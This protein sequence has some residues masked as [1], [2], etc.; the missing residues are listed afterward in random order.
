MGK[1]IVSWSPIH[2]QSATTTNIAALASMFALKVPSTN[3]ITH[4]QLSFSTLES[5]FGKEVIVEGFED[6][7]INAL[8]R[9]IKSNL[10]KPEAVMDYTETIYSKRLEILGGMKKAESNMDTLMDILIL[11]IR[12]AY[13]FLWIDAHSGQQNPLSNRLLADADVVLVNLPQ[14]RYILDR[15]FKGDLFPDVL[16]NKPHVVLIANYDENLSLSIRKIK[17]R[18]GVKTPIFPVNYSSQLKNACNELGLAEFFYRNQLVEKGNPSYPYIKSLEK[19]NKFIS[20]E[21][22]FSRS[23]LDV[24][25]GD[26]DE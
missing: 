19:I 18:Y 1:T 13:D 23:F 9:L 22:G 15:F 12:E 24:D 11:A 2:G 10:L 8:E 17:R 16:K 14:N 20:K 6:A 5:L 26:D 21:T 7:G 25:E 4:T 3:L